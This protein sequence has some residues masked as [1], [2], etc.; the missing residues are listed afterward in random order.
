MVTRSVRL[1][2]YDHSFIIPVGHPVFAGHF[3][4]N[5]VVPAALLLDETICA[6]AAAGDLPIN[7]CS[8]SSAKFY[9]PVAPGELLN[10]RVVVADAMPMTFEV[11]AGARLIASGDFSGH[12][13]ER[14]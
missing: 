7:D 14:L 12:V 10:L 3:P 9:S 1:K 4:G 11:H 13:W 2:Y 8:I 5:P 6:I